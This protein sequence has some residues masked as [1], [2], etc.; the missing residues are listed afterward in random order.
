MEKDCPSKNTR[1]KNDKL[2]K[3]SNKPHLNDIDSYGNLSGFIVPDDYIEYE[4]GS[5]KLG[6]DTSDDEVIDIDNDDEIIPNKL[7]SKRVV[8]KES[9]KSELMSMA[10]NILLNALITN[11]F[12]DPVKKRKDRKSVA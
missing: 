9:E 6:D 4:D 3:Q 11:G 10:S 8:F 1:S 7:S 5:I 12:D 2:Q